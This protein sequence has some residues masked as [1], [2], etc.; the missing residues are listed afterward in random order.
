MAVT[1]RGDDLPS[2]I[3]AFRAGNGPALAEIYARWSPLV[4]SI[5]LRSL[6][7]VP[8][9]EEVTKRVF[10]SAWTSRDTFDPNRTRLPAWLIGITGTRIAEAQ[11]ARSKHVHP[12]TQMT[13]VSQMDGKIEPADVAER[14]VLADE[15]SRLDA[16]PQQVLRMA[17]YDGLTS[18]QIAERTGLA[19]G[20]VAGHLRRSLLTLRQR[21]E[22]QTDAC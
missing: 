16:E 21:L 5:A 8:D 11:A 9:A 10:T 1:Q 17:L 7:N 18:S 14:L 13:T 20:T 4:Y 6:G 15:L 22:V 3:E 19:S 2:V 12:Q